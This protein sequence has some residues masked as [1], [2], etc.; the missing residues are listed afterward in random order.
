MANKDR[1]LIE[2]T[3]A[4]VKER[5]LHES[6]GHDWWHVLRVWTMAVKLTQ[7]YPK[8]NQVHIELAALLH[9]LGDYK[10]TVSSEAE[11][12][13]LRGVMDELRFEST[14]KKDVLSIIDKVSYSKNVGLK[15]KLSID[16]QITQ[17]ADRLDSLGAIGIARVFATSGKAGRS[18]YDP[19]Q[20]VRK[21]VSVEDRRKSTSSAIHHFDEKLLLLKDLLNTKEA[22]EIG[23]KRHQY[24]LNYLQESH[25]EWS[26][27]D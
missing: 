18:L 20:I 27:K 5:M 6:T 24:M 23:E 10:V 13:I 17:D 12:S 22:R 25:T 2:K 11:E 9:D 7:S 14:L 15:Q 26:G 8:A 4:Y 21:Y 19:T 3:A 1:V 16:A